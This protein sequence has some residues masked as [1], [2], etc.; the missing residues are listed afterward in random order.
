MKRFLLILTIFLMSGI[1]SGAV[2]DSFV[3]DGTSST[4]GDMAYIYSYD[5]DYNYGANLNLRLGNA[6]IPGGGR[7]FKA[8][9]RFNLLDDSMKTIGSVTWDSALVGLVVTDNV[10]GDGTSVPDSVGITVH[11]LTTAGWQEGTYVADAGSPTGG[12]TWDSA[13]AVG[14][15]SMSDPLDW[16]S[17]GGDYNATP[18]DIGWSN[19]TVWV[20]GA[21]TVGDTIWFPVSGGAVSD[22]MGNH[23]G[24]ILVTSRVANGDDGA[25][26]AYFKVGSDDHFTEATRPILRVYYTSGEPPAGVTQAIMI[27]HD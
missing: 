20:V 24:I 16:T 2:A 3:L 26:Y 15:G 14:T 8:L 18:E 5:E 21:Q 4:E 9:L 6:W 19:D 1:W 22:T 12:V 17:D 27:R 13:S 11:K 10:I 25:N 7:W 23:A